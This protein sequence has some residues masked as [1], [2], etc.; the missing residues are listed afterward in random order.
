VLESAYPRIPPKLNPQDN[1]PNP[2]RVIHVGAPSHAEEVSLAKR[3]TLKGDNNDRLR[4]IHHYAIS[5]SYSSW[6]ATS[7]MQSVHLRDI[8]PALGFEHD[9]LLSG[10]LAVSSLHLALLNPSDINIASAIKYHTEAICQVQ[11]HLTNVSPDNVAAL[12]SFSCLIAS[13]SFGFHQIQTP[14]FNSLKSML[15]V[16]TLIRGIRVIVR[17]GMQWLKNGPFAQSLSI[18]PSNPNASLEPKIE[19]ALSK[20]LQRTSEQKSDSESRDVYTTAIALLRQNFILAAEKPG[21]KMTALPFPILMS[22]KFL[23]SLKGE[24][25]LALVI[26]ANYAVLLHW[27]RGYVWLRGWGK[28]IV[29]AVKHTVGTKWRDCLEWAMQEISSSDFMLESKGLLKIMET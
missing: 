1:I 16:F 28:Q 2:D 5:T 15:E 7:V 27:L 10:L 19:A 26:F 11:P 13:Y 14:S 24:D 3:Y 22:D 25:P 21:V 8:V 29:E 9:F 20:L 23:E 17:D 4:L 12:F 18:S 6:N